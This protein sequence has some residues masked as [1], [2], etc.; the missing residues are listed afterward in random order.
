[1]IARGALPLIRDTQVS[2]GK[3]VGGVHV[4]S[5]NLPLGDALALMADRLPGVLACALKGSSKQGSRGH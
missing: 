5:A 3:L 1:M 4:F 2:H